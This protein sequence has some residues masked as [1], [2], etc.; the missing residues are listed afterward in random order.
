MFFSSFVRKQINNIFFS[1]IYESEKHNGVAELL[2]ILG[3][4]INGF[5]MPLKEEHKLFLL[6]VLL[7]LHKAKSLVVYHPQLTYCVKQ[8]LDKDPTL[9]EPVIRGLLMYLP[10]VHSTKEVM[11]LTELEE[12]LDVIE[13]VEFHKIMEPLFKR[14]AACV[15][16]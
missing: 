8:F 13:P 9:A 1:F 10:K 2:E 6:R 12:I 15:S 3:S 7:P 5:A 14:L 11:F 4:I 16:S